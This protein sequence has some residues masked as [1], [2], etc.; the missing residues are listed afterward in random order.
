MLRLD[1]VLVGGVE[2]AEQF[3]EDIAHSVE[4]SLLVAGI[5]KT[6]R[7]MRL[8]HR[9]I[10]QGSQQSG[11]CRLLGTPGRRAEAK[12]ENDEGVNKLVLH[13]DVFYWSC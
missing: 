13:Y 9:S 4:K 5:S 10:E 12:A 1:I 7:G 6:V 11:I 2:L 8:E 3:G